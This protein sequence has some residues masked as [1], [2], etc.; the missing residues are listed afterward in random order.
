MLSPPFAIRFDV[1][2]IT[3]NSQRR[4]GNDA[5]IASHLLVQGVEGSPNNILLFKSIRRALINCSIEP[6]LR[7]LARSANKRSREKGNKLISRL[8]GVPNALLSAVYLSY[9]GP[10]TEAGLKKLAIMISSITSQ[11]CRSLDNGCK[12]VKAIATWAH[13]QLVPDAQLPFRRNDHLPRKG[14]LVI[15]DFGIECKVPEDLQVIF[16]TMATAGR[17][18]PHGTNQLAAEKL[19]QFL[20]DLGEPRSIGPEA[21]KTVRRVATRIARRLKRIPDETH[22]SLSTSACIEVTRECGGRAT[23]VIT[24]IEP[25][26]KKTKE[27]HWTALVD[28]R[29]ISPFKLDTTGQLWQIAYREVK[30]EGLFKLPYLHPS[31]QITYD[32]VDHAIGDQILLWAVTEAYKLGYISVEG[33]G[34]VEVDPL[35]WE[36]TAKFTFVIGRP[37]PTKITYVSETGYRIRPINVGPA[38]TTVLQQYCRH[39]VEPCLWSDRRNSQQSL[40]YIVE[41]VNKETKL[42]PNETWVK[43][44]DFRGASNLLSFDYSEALIDGLFEGLDIPDNH[45]I[46]RLKCLLFGPRVLYATHR[47]PLGKGRYYDLPKRAAETQHVCGGLLGDSFCFMVLTMSSLVIWEAADMYSHTERKF[48]EW[49]DS[50]ALTPTPGHSLGQ[51]LGDDAV[52]FTTWLFI[53]AYNLIVQVVRMALSPDKDFQSQFCATYTEQYARRTDEKSVFTFFDAPK[54]RYF[55]PYQRATGIEAD[56]REVALL[57][58]SDASRVARYYDHPSNLNF[59]FIKQRMVSLYY[60]HFPNVLALENKGY[61]VGFPRGAGGLSAPILDEKA[62]VE[63]HAGYAALIKAAFTTTQPEEFF[64]WCWTLSSLAK[65]SKKGLLTSLDDSIEYAS[66]LGPQLVT[67]GA[68]NSTQVRMDLEHLGIKVNTRGPWLD[69][70]D[71]ARKGKEHLKLERLSD[72]LAEIE[73]TH[74]FELLLVRGVRNGKPVSVYCSNYRRNFDRILLDLVKL[75]V[76]ADQQAPT[77]TPEF[78]SLSINRMA[79]IYLPSDHEVIELLRSGPTLKVRGRAA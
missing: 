20:L 18:L 1:S 42:T 33:D 63:K 70:R 52:I 62:Y 49:D 48:P 32:G 9:R 36:P 47:V 54:A 44:T 38:C 31:G 66:Y 19:D 67:G 77:G 57:K 24:S 60:H 41:W 72:L 17:A 35:L 50:L 61:P 51:I 29:G 53:L 14:N 5:K 34:P 10:W 2:V 79:D 75:E 65:G 74:E 12:M 40:Y 43:S 55:S 25:F 30:V 26:L 15:T 3:K 11:T 8:L 28:F 4:L 27:S 58:A 56:G 76:P 13:Q 39:L 69:Y 45:P 16:M 22:F 64:K 68:R 37:Y 7:Y 23:E 73:R 59:R 78:D 6:E 46:R 71:L 21:V